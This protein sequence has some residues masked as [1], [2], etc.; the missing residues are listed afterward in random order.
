MKIHIIRHADPDYER[1][2][3]TASG[4]LE[5][6]ALSK[7]MGKMGIDEIY[8]SPVPRAMYTM[9]Y[10]AERVGLQPTVLPWTAE[11]DWRVQGRDGNHRAAWNT[12]GEWVR[13]ERPFPNQD[14]WHQFG[15]FAEHD[16]RI[17]YTE[18]QQNSD[19]FLESFGYKREDGVYRIVKS[20]R[21]QIAVFC[22]LGFGITWLSHL[23]ELPLP[24]IWS[25]FYMTPSSVTTILMDERSPEIAVPR[26]LQWGD[27]SHLYEAGLPLSTQG[28]IANID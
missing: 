19:R 15:P 24:L 17:K 1:D 26:C 18:M 4:H 6:Q 20:N 12:D 8:S 27:T 13:G 7:R 23:L 9:Q 2:T 14:N 28:I 21:K 11:L 10:T 22:H 25:G 16:F 3:I 5:A